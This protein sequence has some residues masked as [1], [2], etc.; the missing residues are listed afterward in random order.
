M[1]EKSTYENKVFDHGNIRVV[2][3]SFMELNTS[4]FISCVFNELNL[5]GS[6]FHFC[7]MTDT[8]FN[9][10]LFYWASFLD[11]SYNCLLYTSPSPRDR[12]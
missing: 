7:T 11:N 2:E 8:I 3:R 10:V 5:E 1:C 9:N 12:G 6:N 4:E